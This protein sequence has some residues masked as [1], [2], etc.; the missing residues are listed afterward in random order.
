M[1]SYIPSNQRHVP[2]NTPRAYGLDLS[3]IY[4]LNPSHAHGLDLPAGESL[5]RSRDNPS[6]RVILENDGA[7][8]FSPQLQ[9]K[10]PLVRALRNIQ[11]DGNG[12]GHDYSF[13]TLPV[14]W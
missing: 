13:V 7:C 1:C 11:G 6:S 9:R 14:V 12:G 3:H 8:D 10:G 2:I 4:S 5:Y